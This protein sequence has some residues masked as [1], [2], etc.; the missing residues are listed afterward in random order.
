[1]AEK[2]A[3]ERGGYITDLGFPKLQVQT[4]RWRSCR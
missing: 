3:W 4:A 2:A 1:M